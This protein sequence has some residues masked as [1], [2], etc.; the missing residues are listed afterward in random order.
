V[1]KLILKMSMSADGFVGADG[2][3]DWLF[4]SLDDRATAWTM[5]SSWNASLHILG[6]KTFHDM[7][8]WWPTGDPGYAFAD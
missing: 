6:S 7:A 3:I 5:D 2:R 4:K 8:A 1:R